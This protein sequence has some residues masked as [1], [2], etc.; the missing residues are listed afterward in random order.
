[1]NKFISFL[2]RVW[3]ARPL[4]A[5]E[6]LESAEKYEERLRTNQPSNPQVVESILKERDRIRT[7]FSQ[8]LPEVENRISI[9]ITTDALVE[10]CAVFIWKNHLYVLVSGALIGRPY[11]HPDDNGLKA[12]DWLARHEAAHVR[13]H[14]LFWLFH[15]RRLFRIS[16][17]ISWISAIFLRIF[18]S[19]QTFYIWLKPCLF[20]LG[21]F[22]L[23][24][25]I[26]GI[27]FEWKA[28]LSATSSIQ[29]SEVLKETEKSLH[30]M[31]VQAR[32]R[33][34]APIGFIYYAFNIIFIDPHPP[35][36]ARRWLLRRRLRSLFGKERA[37]QES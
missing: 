31:H 27:V 37:F 20:L 30:R 36:I 7:L 23:L 34:P 19:S 12:W 35:F 10:N 22:W 18:A 5:S 24:Q 17:T 28:D 33:W 29:D 26:V 4:L 9:V 25:T 15:T 1:M 32:S 14:H 6:W 13:N 8:L 16:Y 2:A 11:D 21:G 3:D